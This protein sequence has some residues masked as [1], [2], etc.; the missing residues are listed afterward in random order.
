MTKRLQRVSC[1]ANR[2]DRIG[3]LGQGYRLA[4][5]ADVDVDGAFADVAV[6]AP[7]GIEQL[8]AREHPPR[9]LHEEAQQAIFGRTEPDRLSLPLDTM[10]LYGPPAMIFVRSQGGLSHCETEYSTPADI[11]AGANVLLLSA[12]ALASRA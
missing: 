4:Q 5:S 3:G 7:Y 1:R 6:V 8:A 2:T 9:M 11:E 10:R 12:L